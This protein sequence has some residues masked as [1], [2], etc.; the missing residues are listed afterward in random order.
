MAVFEPRCVGVSV[1][2][3]TAW[4]LPPPPRTPGGSWAQILTPQIRGY[5]ITCIS[6][7]APQMTLMQTVLG[8]VLKND[9]KLLVPFD[10]TTLCS[11]PLGT[12]P[13]VCWAT[14]T[15]GVRNPCTP[16][17][18]RMGLYFVWAGGVGLA[19]YSFCKAHRLLLSV[20]SFIQQVFIEPQRCAKHCSRCWSHSGDSEHSRS[21]CS[22]RDCV[23]VGE[24]VAGR[25]GVHTKQRSKR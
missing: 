2:L 22:G 10:C 5:S 3:S 8:C 19:V 11:V 6:T 16:P 15:E 13:A 24:V 14:T 12:L 23:L 9:W 21:L 7:H 17:A 20:F 18:H 4:A 1:C 25:W